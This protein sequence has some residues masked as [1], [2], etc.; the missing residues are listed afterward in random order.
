M[1]RRS[2]LALT[3]AFLAARIPSAEAKTPAVEWPPKFPAGR[4]IVRP[5]TPEEKKEAGADARFVIRYEVNVPGEGRYGRRFVTYE[6]CNLNDLKHWE[7]IEKFAR[8]T[9]ESEDWNAVRVRK[10]AKKK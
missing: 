6:S 9:W 3:P 1:N 5:V 4:P 8:E 7:F 10:L 2:F